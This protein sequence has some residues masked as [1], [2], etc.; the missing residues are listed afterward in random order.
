MTGRT[1]PIRL[2]SLA[3]PL[4][5]GGVWRVDQAALSAW[6]LAGAWQLPVASPYDVGLPLGA[7]PE[8][9]I[10]RGVMRTRG[11]ETHQGVDLGNGRSGDVVR[12][13]AAGLVVC[14]TRQDDGS[15]YGSHVVVAH[16]LAEGG[17]V[18]S[19]YAHL[20]TGSLAV[21]SGDPVA[22]GAPLGRVGSTGRSTG[23]HLHFEIRQPGDPASRWEHGRV[24]DPLAFVEAHMPEA[25]TD[26]SWARPFLVWAQY[27]GLVAATVGGSDVLTRASWWR[28]LASGARQPTPAASMQALRDSLIAWSILPENSSQDDPE[29]VPGWREIIR[30]VRRARSIGVGL[31]RFGLLEPALRTACE[32]RLGERRP[33]QALGRLSHREETPTLA[34]AC[35]LMA[36]LAPPVDSS[37]VRAPDA[38]SPV[39]TAGP[40][41]I[42]K[43][44][45]A[46]HRAAAGAKR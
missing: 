37:A 43:S 34:D 42:A 12:A 24:L 4:L 13:A 10:V 20:K 38:E 41:R 1:P 33:Q 21:R 44:L 30:D 8:F 36:D 31:A 26:S 15:G 19:V 6:P 23:P 9:Q 17:L 28:M 14:A 27:G 18:F 16:R 46:R 39:A 32:S 29:A 5:L 11:R 25:R 22:A 2:W 3:V 40:K 45:P 35:L 7:E